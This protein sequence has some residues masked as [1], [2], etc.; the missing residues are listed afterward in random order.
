MENIKALENAM[1]FLNLTPD[2]LSK[3]SG[4]TEEKIREVLSGENP[5]T[6][7]MASMLNKAMNLPQIGLPDLE[8]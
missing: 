5:M 3:Q 4:V 7:D 6:K 2:V 1:R 8:A